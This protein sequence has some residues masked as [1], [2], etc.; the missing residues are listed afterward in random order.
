[1]VGLVAI[2][3]A[4]LVRSA[5]PPFVPRLPVEVPALIPGTPSGWL[6]AETD[7]VQVLALASEDA[8][9]AYVQNIVAQ[10]ANLDAILPRDLRITWDRPL[11]VILYGTEN[12]KPVPDAFEGAL[13]KSLTEVARERAAE[14]GE[15]KPLEVPVEVHVAPGSWGTDIDTMMVFN[16]V[17]PKVR[18]SDLSTVPATDYVSFLLNARTPPLP[19][20]FV[21][22]FSSLFVQ[23]YV[24]GGDWQVPPLVWISPA[25]SQAMIR[26]KSIPAEL[27]PLSEVFSY[28]NSA[29]LP[30]DERRRMTLRSEGA[31]FVRWVLEGRAKHGPEALWKFVREARPGADLEAQ[32]AGTFGMSTSAAVESMRSYLPTSLRKPLRVRLKR[33]GSS[34]SVE[35]RPATAAEIARVKGEW[36]RI[37]GRGAGAVYSVLPPFYFGQARRTL[38][39]GPDDAHADPE[40]LAARGLMAVDS[41]DDAAAEPLLA[42]ACRAD[43][44]RP[45][46]VVELARIALEK[47]RTAAGADGK[48]DGDVVGSIT[49]QLRTVLGS[50]PPMGRAYQVMAEAWAAAAEPPAPAELETLVTAVHTLPRDVP[51]VIAVAKLFMDLGQADQARS[52]I[53]VGLAHVV[54]DSARRRLFA[55]RSAARASGSK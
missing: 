42:A 15:G 24:E 26:N 35:L 23:S 31:L 5:P 28:I 11:G 44:P 39:G 6:W 48:L 10:R 36:E 46:A 1:M 9:R 29:T 22:S 17:P 21:E 32:F 47:A 52:L 25:Q 20:W 45:R 54:D 51:M 40:L 19:L 41:G 49:A 4:A 2:A 18:V 53:E 12:A 16:V 38:A 27:L 43:K 7:G 13:S 14:K 34:P 37:A 30:A 3:G 55:L 8:T 33:E 50:H